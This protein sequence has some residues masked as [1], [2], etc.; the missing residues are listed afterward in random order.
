MSAGVTAAFGR[1]GEFVS[2]RLVYPT[3][4]VMAPTHMEALITA[5]WMHRIETANL[6]RLAE[7]DAERRAP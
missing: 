5:L 3:G 2:L 1:I 7:M 4:F 6:R